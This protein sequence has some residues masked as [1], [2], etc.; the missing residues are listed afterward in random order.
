MIAK[1][2]V[3]DPKAKVNTDCT[4]GE[5]CVIEDGV[6]LE[7]VWCWAPC[8]RPF[9]DSNRCRN[10]YRGRSPSAVVHF[11]LLLAQSKPNR[12]LVL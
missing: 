6:V 10:C 7:E 12:R 3:I 9:W 8:G 5:Y 1:T 2:A 4:I 11:L